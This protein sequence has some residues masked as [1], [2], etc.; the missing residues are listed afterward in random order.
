MR[1]PLALAAAVA[2]V[3]IVVGVTIAST[4]GSGNSVSSP[5]AG[6]AGIPAPPAAA[7]TIP[8]PRPLDRSGTTAVWATLTRTASAR[9]APSP[10]ARVVARVD[11]LTPEGTTNVVLVRRYARGSDRRPWVLAQIAGRRSGLSGWIPRSAIGPGGETRTRLIVDRARLTLT[12][13]RARRV[14]MRAPVGIGRS[15]Y[16][17]PPGRYYVRSRLTRYASPAYG[18]LAFGTSA[19]S[20]LSDWP[21]GG[22]IGIHGTDRPGLIPGRISHGCIRMRNADILRL[23]RLLPVGTPL[24]VL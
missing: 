15:A 10:A 12:L 4:R 23:G 14:V 9:S 24:T 20:D 2:G 3:G 6:A 5:L 1:G 16:P 18:P 7:F 22:F 8:A 19:Q 13:V 21:G 17:T 11:G